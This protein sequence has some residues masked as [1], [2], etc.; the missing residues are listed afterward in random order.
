MELGLMFSF[1]VYTF[2][3]DLEFCA[4]HCDYNCYFKGYSSF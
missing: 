4:F 2:S 3:T 1:L